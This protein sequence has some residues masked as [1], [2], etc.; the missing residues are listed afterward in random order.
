MK[1]EQLRNLITKLKRSPKIGEIYKLYCDEH[2]KIIKDKT[3]LH[4]QAIWNK[5]LSDKLA[6][7]RADR[8]TPLEFQVLILDELQQKQLYNTAITATRIMV[9]AFDFA[10]AITVLQ[11]NPLRTVY[12]LP[13]LRMLQKQ[14]RQHL[15]HRPSFN[16]N[17]LRIDLKELIK[18]FKDK[19][20][21]QRINLLYLSLALLLRPGEIVKIK[22]QELDTK[23]KCLTVHDTKTL[24]EFKVPVDDRI[25]KLIEDT[26]QEFGNH[27]QGYIFRGY[28]Y[29][30]H[31][32]SQTLNV[33]LKKL[34]YKGKLCAH[35]IR[36]VGS[37]FF[38]H[39]SKEVPPYVREAILQHS[40]GKVEKAYRHD[41][42]YLKQRR[43][44]M[45]LWYDYLDGLF[46]S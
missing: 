6:S 42:F 21:T 16:H 12:D 39:H 30:E 32:S 2:D 24:E 23:S 40:V 9:A 36:A 20:T 10:V 31:L 28:R 22:I 11:S 1:I 15:Q 18:T 45:K 14:A 17:T 13:I 46:N 27:D 34:G 25:I 33:A 26:Y 4:L 8:L 43:T 19:T 35:G 38:A 41:D 29:S 44:A 3:R 5:H 37:N 7:L